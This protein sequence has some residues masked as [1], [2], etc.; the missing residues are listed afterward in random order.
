MPNL[1][2]EAPQTQTAEQRL[3]IEKSKLELTEYLLAEDPLPMVIR[4]HLHIERELLNFIEA[5]GHP[6]KAIP[7]KYAHRI[8]LA[9][10]LGLSSE[11]TKQLVF[12][13]KLRN[14]FAHDQNAVISKSDAE[15]FDAAH[16]RSDTVVEDAY[17]ETLTKLEDTS[18]KLSVYDLEP[19]DQ[20]VFHIIALWAGIAVTAVR[21]VEAG[22]SLI[23]NTTARS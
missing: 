14:R 10:R 5:C 4:A 17:R 1:Y 15:T 6:A 12:L 7:S 18:R 2:P 9:S 16:D 21:T 8:H 11:F 13:G 19:K 3:G 20:V 23:K 22:D